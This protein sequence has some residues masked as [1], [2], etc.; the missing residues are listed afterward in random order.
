MCPSHRY[1]SHGDNKLCVDQ[2]IRSFKC[3]AGIRHCYEVNPK[4]SLLC[5]ETCS[6]F[7][8]LRRLFHAE[9][10]FCS[11][12]HTSSMR[13]DT[14]TTSTRR[15]QTNRQRVLCT[16]PTEGTEPLLLRQV[17]R[18][19]GVEFKMEPLVRTVLIVTT[20]HLQC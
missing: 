20:D 5:S 3:P 1:R 4:E 10:R 8:M 9:R 12:L 11:I 16:I 2:F 14:Y 17:Q 18:D 13:C 15:T 6:L 19:Q 7:S